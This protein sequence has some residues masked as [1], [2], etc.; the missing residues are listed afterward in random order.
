MRPGDQRVRRSPGP[1]PLVTRPHSTPGSATQRTPASRPSKGGDG[2]QTLTGLREASS[3]GHSGPQ[4]GGAGGR[5]PAGRPGPRP[6][7]PSPRATSGAQITLCTHSY[8][9][10]AA[11]AQRTQEAETSRAHLG[12]S[13]PPGTTATVPDSPQ[14]PFRTRI[15]HSRGYSG[16]SPPA[17]GTSFPSRLIPH[18][19]LK[20]H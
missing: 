3:P 19:L 6:G 9:R 12:H 2:R 15:G 13:Q 17:M 5:E 8:R 18:P 14:P 16:H 20:F 11:H 7:Q 4:E 1:R 10:R